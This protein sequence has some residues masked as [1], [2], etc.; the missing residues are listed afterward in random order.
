MRIWEKWNPK[1]NEKPAKH[2]L[3]ASDTQLFLNIS[4]KVQ[5]NSFGKSDQN[6]RRSQ[7]LLPSVGVVALD[8]KN[9]SI[10]C[11]FLLFEIYM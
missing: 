8:A 5:K 2:L 11:D 6:K 4:V 7:E 3:V 1:Q 9:G 10:L